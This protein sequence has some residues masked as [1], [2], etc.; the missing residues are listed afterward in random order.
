VICELLGLPLDDR[1]KFIFGAGIHFCLGHQLARVEGRCAL[2]LFKRWPKL[3][4]A[5]ENSIAGSGSTLTT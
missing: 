5:V 3:E 2:A 4:L 1:P